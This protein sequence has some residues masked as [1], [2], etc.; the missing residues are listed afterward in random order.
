MHVL[1]EVNLSHK[2]KSL[3]KNLSYSEQQKVAIARAMVNHPFLVLADEPCAYLDPHST[4]EIMDIFKYINA[5]GATILFAT[6]NQ[7]LVDTVGKRSV[8]LDRG[9]IIN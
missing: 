7:V 2:F 8:R 4:H 1:R 9:R 3:A 5:W 6:Q